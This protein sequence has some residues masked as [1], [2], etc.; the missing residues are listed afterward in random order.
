M[1]VM[2]SVTAIAAAKAKQML[3]FNK[4]ASLYSTFFIS[5]HNAKFSIIS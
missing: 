1:D 5:F 2:N 4:P 3:W